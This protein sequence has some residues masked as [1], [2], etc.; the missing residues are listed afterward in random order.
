[1]PAFHTILVAAFLLVTAGLLGLTVHQ[2][3]S[4]RDAVMAWQIPRMAV[5]WPITF[6]GVIGLLAI[7]AFNTGSLVPSWVF[8]GYVMGGLMWFAATVIAGTV[9]VSRHGVVAGLGRRDKTL[10][11]C[12]VTDHFEIEGA[13]KSVTV[14]LYRSESNQTRRLEVSVPNAHRARFRRVVSERLEQRPPRTTERTPGK[15]ATS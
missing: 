4:V 13:R 2:R 8:V 14:F 15:R 1:M 6:V 3:Q 5:A 12:Q 7:Y 9:V 11:W 10:P